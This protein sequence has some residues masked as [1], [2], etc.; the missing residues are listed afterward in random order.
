MTGPTHGELPSSLGSGRVGIRLIHKRDAKVLERFLREDRQWLGPWEATHPG[1]LNPTPGSVTLKPVIK[2]LRQ[3]FQ[4]GRG[5]PFVMTY[6]GEVVGQLSASD[7]SRGAL[8]SGSIGYW[9]A[10][11][12]AG[13]GIT[14]V[15]VAL[16]I[17]YLFS[18]IGLH[19]VE[20]CIR[21]ENSASL[22]IVEKLG[23]RY[24]GRRKSYI[25]ID[26]AWRDH[27]SFAVTRDEVHGSMLARLDD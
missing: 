22:R 7:I 17:D 18:T 16:A 21:P 10:S 24:E 3:Q 13:R 2:R 9:I 19:R 27:E 20:I 15:A 14:P 26:G 23:L 1:G 4:E 25:H 11:E 12:Y 5:V 6:D 8:W